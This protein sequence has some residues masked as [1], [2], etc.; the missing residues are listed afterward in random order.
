MT[1]E[2]SVQ[3]QKPNAQTS[4]QQTPDSSQYVAPTPIRCFTGA[5]IAAPLGYGLYLLTTAIAQ[6]FAEKPV[7]MGNALA[8]NIA[9]LVR[10]L[11]VGVAALGTGIFAIATLGLVLL[12][13]QLLLKKEPQTPS[14]R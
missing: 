8:A 9:V 7:P 11:V 2:S 10:T 14:E 1:D 3:P 5:L 13:I 6:T 4:D 12:G